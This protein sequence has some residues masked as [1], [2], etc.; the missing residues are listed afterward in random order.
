MLPERYTTETLG[1]GVYKSA[2]VECVEGA[3]NSAL[4]ALETWAAR[5]APAGTTD[6]DATLV[7]KEPDGTTYHR[8]EWKQ[9]D[10]G[11]N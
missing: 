6:A 7:A 2:T 3:K 5:N 1:N 10:Q 8:I 11:Q 4:T 9:D